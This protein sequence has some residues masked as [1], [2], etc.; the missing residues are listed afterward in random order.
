VKQPDAVVDGRRAGRRRRSWWPATLLVLAAATS[1]C[2]TW[3]YRVPSPDDL[4]HVIPWFDHMIE[5]KYIH[6]YETAAVPRYTPAGTVPVTGGEPDWSG[7]WTTGKTTTANALKNPYATAAG[8]STRP[9]PPGPEIPVIPRELEAAGDTLYQN[10]CAACHGAAGDAK[11]PVSSR[12]GAPSLLSGRARAYSDGY[13]YS[14][15]RY[16]RGVMPRYGD[17]VYLPADRWAIVNHVRKLQGQTPLAP[18]PAGA[19]AGIAPGPS[20]TGSTGERP[21]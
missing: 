16:G 1:G 19:S 8:D 21:R 10:Y 14:I 15:I 9:S 3:Y 4:W 18:E 17:K 5:A 13:I 7:E 2:E 6:P 12:I 11:G 20:A